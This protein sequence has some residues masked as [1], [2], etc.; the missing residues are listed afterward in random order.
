M[1]SLAVM[2]FALLSTALVVAEEVPPEAMRYFEAEDAAIDA[3]RSSLE[4]D[5][6]KAKRTGDRRLLTKTAKELKDMEK[7][8][9]EVKPKI[10]FPLEVGS[11]GYLPSHSFEV[12]QILA[13]GETFG[14]LKHFYRDFVGSGNRVVARDKSSSVQLVIR[15]VDNAN[16][17]AESKQQ[18]E[19]PMRVAEPVDV[20]T[21]KGAKLRLLVLEPFDVTTF[22]QYRPQ[23]ERERK[24]AEK[25]SK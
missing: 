23:Y 7:T 1:R 13:D 20:I 22:D 3:M 19:T 17:T 18:F 2:T 12:A 15:G 24:A 14:E 8:R 11:I 4:R 6:A 10:D 16:W 21:T 25:K 5:F 9:P